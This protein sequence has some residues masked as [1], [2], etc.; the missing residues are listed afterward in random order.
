MSSKSII[1]N[2]F[3][4]KS[5]DL[6]GHPVLGD[7]TFI[8]LDEND[9][10]ESIYFTVLIGS[11]GTGKSE[12][13]SCLLELFRGIFQSKD[14]SFSVQYFFTLEFYNSGYLFK[15]GNQTNIDFIDITAKNLQ[16]RYPKPK[17][18]LWDYKKDKDN[19]IDV[20]EFINSL[21]SNIIANS[22]M[23][24][25]KFIAP[26]KG[27]ETEDFP[28]YKYL[29][30]RSRPQQASTRGYVRKTVEFIVEQINSDVFKE[31]VNN[32]SKF[33]GYDGSILVQYKTAYTTKFFKGD[34]TKE[35]LDSFFNEIEAKY[36]EKDSLPP[37]KL[38]HY[39]S[40]SKQS[41]YIEKIVYFMN[42]LHNN[43]RFSPIY[44]SSANHIKYLIDNDLD[45]KLLKEEY[46]LIDE[47]RKLGFVSPPDIKLIKGE[48]ALGVQQ[49]S[50]GEFHFFSTMIG[51]M[52]T[53]KPGSLVLIDEPEISL[54]PNWQMK[55]LEFF[56][57][58]FSNPDYNTCHVIIATHSHFL[59]SDLKGDSA[60][61][62][63][64]KKIENKITTI[65]IND[66]TFGW[67]AE[68]VLLDI[69]DVPT[70]RNYYVAEKISRI[71][72]QATLNGITSIDK[73]KIELLKLND[74]MSEEDP[75]R[76]AIQKLIEKRGWQS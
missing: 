72:K 23:L 39:K 63:G 58:L 29:G 50:S 54:H 40:L 15:F 70:T 60:K 71:I 20:K 35:L 62:I 4:L 2:G 48:Q 52:A 31:G 66:N 51:L 44:R 67:S 59:I 22:L 76:Y 47:L 33:L 64:L 26:R 36:R 14:R 10:S 38:N 27:K 16:K 41:G 42:S 19:V 9:S 75:L 57:H 49:T 11:N 61:I 28:I 12:L 69:F 53:I 30:V 7:N 8:F 45:H 74:S 13:F 1:Y 5:L 34:L 73:H 32:L 24:T 46:T 21:P 56:R 55:Y 6:K 37:F 25:D 18:Y 3:K 17:T 65:D 43:A 68:Q